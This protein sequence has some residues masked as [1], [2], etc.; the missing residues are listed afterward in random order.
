MQ[1]DQGRESVIALASSAGFK[2]LELHPSR[3]RG[4]LR[5]ANTWR[6][7]VLLTIDMIPRRG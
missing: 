7:Y 4:L 6:N 2:D 5:V 1:L 3:A